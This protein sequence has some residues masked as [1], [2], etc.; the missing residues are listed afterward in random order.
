[1]ND[2]LEVALL[3]LIVLLRFDNHCPRCKAKNYLYPIKGRKVFSCGLCGTHT[4]PLAGTPLEKSSTPVHKWLQAIQLVVEGA[5]AK[6]L[7]RKL[8]V[9]YKTAWRMKRELVKW[10]VK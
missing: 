3:R 10:V 7:E 4:S 5:S 8:G 9:A 2:P 6:E 1:M